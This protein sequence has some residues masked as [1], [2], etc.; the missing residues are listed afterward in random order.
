MISEFLAPLIETWP[1]GLK[2]V[3]IGAAITALIALRYFI[4]TG[5]AFGFSMLIGKMA[6]WRRLQK[7]PFTR[8]QVGREIGYSMLSVLTFTFVVGLIFVMTS[9]GWTQIYREPDAYG[10]V[11]FWL[12]IPVI[13]LIQDFYFYWMHRISHRPGIYERVHKTHHLSTNPSAFSAFAF[14]PLEA[15]L[16]IGIFFILVLII[17]LHTVGLLTAGLISL[18]YN[19]Y[20][21]LGYEIM[22]RFVARSALGYWFNKSAYHNQHHRTYKYNYGLYTVIW[23]RLHGTLHPHADRLYDAAT[24]KPYRVGD[25]PAQQGSPQA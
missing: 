20:G 19:V 14:H 10:M 7:T 6:P 24:E 15:L 17:P 9:L 25:T 18:A 3:L 22:P 4:F 1:V 5:L 16:E 12:Q 13:L 21:H 11:W 8:A 2:V 23:D